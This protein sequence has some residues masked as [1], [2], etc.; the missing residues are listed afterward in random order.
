MTEGEVQI[1][2]A[3]CFRA[4]E[5]WAAGSEAGA[6]RWF[7]GALQMIGNSQFIDSDEEASW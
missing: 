5:L 1:I 4:A 2:L 7:E 3:S 6:E